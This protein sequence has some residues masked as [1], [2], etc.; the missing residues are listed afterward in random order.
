MKGL[1]EWISDGWM[2][3]DRDPKGYTLR[4]QIEGKWVMGRWE[5]PIPD[6]EKQDA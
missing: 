1:K 4:K 6:K 3:Y 2:I 5:P